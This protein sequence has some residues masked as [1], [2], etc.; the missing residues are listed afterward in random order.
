M[1][2]QRV[3]G[4][5]LDGRQLLAAW[6]EGG[7]DAYWRRQLEMMLAAAGTTTQRPELALA[8]VCIRIGERDRALDH[9]ERFVEAHAGGVVFLGVDPFFRD[10]HGTPRFEAL[11]TR[12]G[13][14]R[15]A[16]PRTASP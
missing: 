13:W 5:R 6:R 16:A 4:F 14:P 8:H 10:L 9:L 1:D 7:P 2:E 3:W 11:L 12:V 15:A